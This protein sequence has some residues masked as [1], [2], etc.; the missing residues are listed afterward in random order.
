MIM[1]PGCWFFLGGI[2]GAA[3]AAGAAWWLH[4]RRRREIEA[5]FLTCSEFC[6]G[7]YRPADN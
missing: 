1:S 4:R 2:Y 6:R 7:L 5:L 3:L